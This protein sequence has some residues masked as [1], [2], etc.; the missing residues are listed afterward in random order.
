MRVSVLFRQFICW[1]LVFLLIIPVTSAE[2]VDLSQ[3]TN[4]EVVEL[5]GKVNQELVTRRIEKR[6][7]LQ[8][9]K[10]VVGIDLPMGSYVLMCKTDDKHDGIVWISSPSDDLTKE[11][12]SVLYDYV[13]YNS[14]EQYRV[15]L[16][17][18][19]IVYLP[20]AATLTISAGI[21][22]Y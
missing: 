4:E 2:S 5:L 12:P 3:M 13:S 6:A 22:F 21:S 20:F 16:E 17:E 9:G 10:Y 19:G 7:T 1:M 15:T 8:A 14:E 18:S 11:Y